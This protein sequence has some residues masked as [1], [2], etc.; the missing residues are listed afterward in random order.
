MT[1]PASRLGKGLN[2]LITPRP[3][4]SLRAAPE[5]PSEPTAGAVREMPLERVKPNPKQPR[6]RFDDTGLQELAASIRTNGILQPILVRPASDDAF[7]IIAGER[8]WRAAR[9]AELTTI[10]VIVH[11]A[12]DSQALEIA[13]IE[14]LQR[15]DLAPL[16]RAAAYRGYLDTFGVSVDDLAKRLSESRA[17]IANYLRLLKLTSR[18]RE[19]LERSALGMAQARAIAGIAEP[20]R[21]LAVAK[22]AYRRNLSVRQVEALVSQPATDLQKSPQPPTGGDRHR[23]ELED[24][25]T[26]K[27]GMKV[28]LKPG[29]RKNSGRVVIHYQS[30]EEFDIIARKLGGTSIME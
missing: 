12:G 19:M 27:L 17:T 30:L 14:N 21:Q 16:E 5:P 9:I 10:P 24:T 6:I 15:E 11:Q 4:T 13:L 2:A 26:R 1:R 25:L 7:E 20:E 18:V 8:R 28:T 3:T 23:R 22:L 29:K